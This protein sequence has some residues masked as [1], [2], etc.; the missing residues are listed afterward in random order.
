MGL[1]VGS[2]R[3]SKDSEHINILGPRAM[4]CPALRLARP[5]TR[6]SVDGAERCVIRFSPGAEG[7][8]SIFP[9]ERPCVHR[10]AKPMLSMSSVLLLLLSAG[11]IYLSCE[12]FVNG[13]E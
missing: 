11:L 4:V 2:S 6:L 10:F 8:D 5:V 1:S 7:L 9:H 12:Y 13:V 3:L